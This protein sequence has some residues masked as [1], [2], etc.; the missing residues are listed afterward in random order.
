M[1]DYVTAHDFVEHV[2]RVVYIG[3]PPVPRYS[4]VELISEIHRVL[5]PGGIFYHRT[6]AFPYATAF[7]DPTHVNI[8]TEITFPDYFCVGEEGRP[9]AGAYGFKG[10]FQLV[11]QAWDQVYLECK[12]QKISNNILG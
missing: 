2:P 9:W 1:F 5:L 12:I 7:Q 8:I 11:S 4:F 6:P 3:Y 10:Q